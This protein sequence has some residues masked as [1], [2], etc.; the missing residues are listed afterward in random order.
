MLR[1]SEGN[2]W[3]ADDLWHIRSYTGSELSST[4]SGSWDPTGIG[5][6]GY[7]PLETLTAHLRAE[8]LGEESPKKNRYVSV[9]VAALALAVLAAALFYLGVPLW[10]GLAAAVIE[11]TTRNFA[12]TYAWP[13]S[14]YHAL[15]MLSFGL[16]AA[17]AVRIPRTRD[18]PP[19]AARGL[20][21]HVGG[22]P[23]AEGPG[24]LPAASPACWW[25]SS[26]T[27]RGGTGRPI[28]TAPSAI[29]RLWSVV[30]A[31]A[32]AQWARA[33]I[34][35]Y[36]VGTRRVVRGR[37][38]RAFRVHRLAHHGRAQPLLGDR[39]ADRPCLGAGRERAVGHPDL[40][41]ARRERP[42][43]R[44]AGSSVGTETGRA[45]TLP[46][47][48]CSP[49]WPSSESSRRSASATPAP[50]RTW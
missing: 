42:P 41:G 16:R 4:W 9:V 27:R 37:C 12:Y 33:D 46:L 44:A 13:S 18:L 19:H 29:E 5:T 48:G 38:P 2:G 25:R 8:L 30:R 21:V 11:F 32:K 7:R 24:P 1:P 15:Q 34:R 31:E 17:R 35:V 49:C 47:P 3:F 10:I 14:G 45:R 22:D 28:R 23:A 26:A 36:S 39:V 43:A 6:P 50:L 40:L 20:G